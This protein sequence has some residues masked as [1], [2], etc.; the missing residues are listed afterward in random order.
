ML[1]LRAVVEILRADAARQRGWDLIHPV[2]LF[3]RKI[4]G[5]D[6][7]SR[8]SASIYAVAVASPELFSDYVETLFV[9]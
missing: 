5:A 4:P 6:Y 8:S 7:N 1:C 3:T 2:A 9:Q